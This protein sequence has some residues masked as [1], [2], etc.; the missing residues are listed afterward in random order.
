MAI[1]AALAMKIAGSSVSGGGNYFKDGR[2]RLA[3]T[4]LLCEKKFKG[5]MF[6]SE[7]RVLESAVEMEGVV[8]NP[9]GSSVSTSVNLDTNVSGFGNVKDFILALLN[10]KEQK[11]EPAR[12]KQMQEVAQALAYLT[13]DLDQ[14]QWNSW[15]QGSEGK[16]LFPNGAP[17]WPG[18]QPARGRII[19]TST[20]RKPIKSRPGETIT[21]HHWKHVAQSQ[22]E[23]AKMRAWLDSNPASSTGMANAPA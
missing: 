22:D 19:D 6:I 4:N 2:Y 10:E 7:F 5:T 13:S 1:S 9:V 12:G 18:I 23:I 16:Y 21:L 3:V 20:Y 14:N 17:P 8:P 11:D 15:S